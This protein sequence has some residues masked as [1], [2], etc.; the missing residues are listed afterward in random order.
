MYLADCV[1]KSMLRIIH[2]RVS[3][4]AQQSLRNVRVIIYMNRVCVEKCP[5]A[6]LCHKHFICKWVVDGTQQKAPIFQISCV[7]RAHL[8]IIHQVG[9]AIHRVNNKQLA[10]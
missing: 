1:K 7:H 4:Y 9:G 10:L 2:V 5:L 6:Q 3:L 8:K